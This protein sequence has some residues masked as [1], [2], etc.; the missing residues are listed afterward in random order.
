MKS[1]ILLLF[2]FCPFTSKTKAYHSH[3][4]FHRGETAIIDTSNNS[5]RTDSIPAWVKKLYEKNSL[6]SM[7]SAIPEIIFFQKLSGSTSYC[8]YMVDDGN[9]RYTFVATQKKRRKFKLAK[10]GNE[11]DQDFSNP[12]Y[13]YTTFEHH[14][15]NNQI[16]MTTI[17]EKAKAKYLVKDQNTMR[18]R[19]GYNMENAGTIKNNTIKTIEVLYTGLLVTK[20]KPR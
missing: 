4:S 15:T 7:N 1:L 16:V 8:L 3:F 14:K 20:T 5:L 12:V 11:C 18:F 10:I 6:E 13:S 19:E 2:L 17:T 9:C